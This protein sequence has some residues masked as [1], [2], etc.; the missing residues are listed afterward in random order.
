[1]KI[2]IDPGHGIDTPGKRSP[3]GSFL[4]YL[5]NR[6][7][8]D[9]LLAKLRDL[10][11]DAEL[12]VTE[13]NDI[14]L[15]TRA[16]RANRICDLLGASNVILLSIHSNA[17]GNGNWMNAKG[18]C[19]YTSRG[20]TGSDDLAECFYDSFSAA[21]PDRRMRRDLFDGD[22]DQEAGFYIITKTRCRAVLLENFFFDNREECAW[23]LLDSTKERIA[24]AIVAGLTTYLGKCG[25][26]KN[27]Y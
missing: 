27:T 19:C 11:I 16:M 1:M 25:S 17:A 6:Q 13:T 21:F 26:R 23:L 10:G 7:E 9:I 18:W 24:D 4:E 15:R 5:W 8:S 3:D 14:P 2:L 12:L 20:K 22:S